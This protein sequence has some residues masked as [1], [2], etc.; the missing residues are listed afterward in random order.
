MGVVHLT[1]ATLFIAFNTPELL[2]ARASRTCAP[3][4]PTVPERAA[5]LIIAG[6][7]GLRSSW[8]IQVACSVVVVH[9]VVVLNRM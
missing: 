5:P 9:A 7:A 1:K 8:H 6:L 3:F 4:M 2:G